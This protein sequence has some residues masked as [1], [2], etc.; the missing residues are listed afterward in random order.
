MASVTPQAKMF[1]TGVLYIGIVTAPAALLL[2]ALDYS[3]RRV[4]RMLGILLLI[5]P[6][7]VLGMVWTEGL[8]AYYWSEIRFIDY[9]GFQVSTVSR[10]LVSG[11][12]RL[13]PMGY[14]FWGLCYWCFNTF[15]R[16]RPIGA[17]SV[18]CLQR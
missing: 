18:R 11:C 6:L 1:W 13:T 2:F 17:R 12:T 9:A 8:Q 7:L 3:G 4:P 16:P 14:A 15:T 10:G 5:E